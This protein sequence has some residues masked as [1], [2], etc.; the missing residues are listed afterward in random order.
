[1]PKRR[2]SRAP[3]QRKANPLN[4]KLILSAFFTRLFGGSGFN[5][6]QKLL[7]DAKDG[8]NE[9]GHSYVFNILISQKGLAFSADKLEQYD[10]NIKGYVEHINRGREHPVVLKYFQYLAV[11]YSEIF[12]DKYFENPISLLNELNDYAIGLDKNDIFFAKDDLTKLAFWMATGSGKT[13]LMHINYLQFMKYNKGP[14]EI[15]LDNILLITPNEGLS[16]QHIR[17]MEQSGIPCGLFNNSTWG[18]F[19]SM[20]EPNHVQ[21]I[22]IHKFTEEKRGQG[23][24][25][26]VEYFGNRNLIFVDEGHKGSGGEKW[27][28]F[29]KELADEG[30]AFEYSATFGQ[31]VAAATKDSSA[32]VEEYGKAILFDYSYKYFYK[33]GYGKD[34]RILNLKEHVTDTSQDMLMLANLVSFYEQILVFEDN[35]ELIKEYNIEKPLWIFVGSKVKGKREQSDILTIVQFL[36]RALKNEGNWTISSIQRI[37]EGKSGLIDD[38][39]RDIYSPTYPDTKLKYI[40]EKGFTPEEIYRGLLLKVFNVPSSAPLH[41]DNLKK[42]KGEIAL[43]AGSSEFFGVINIGDDAEFLNLVRDKEP[44]IPVKDD[45]L[46]SSLFDSINGPKSKVNILIGA[47]KFT[48]GWNSWRVSNMGLLNIGKKEGSQI[49]QLFGRGVRLKGRDFSLKRSSALE[50]APPKYI[51]ILETLSIFGIKA[52]YMDQFRQY[53]EEEVGPIDNF[54]GIPIPIKVNE[55]YLKEGLLVTYVDKERFKREQF[56]R[57]VVDESISAKVNLTPKVEIIA[58]G[59]ESLEM[60]VS[61]NPPRIIDDKYLQILD[62]EKIYF[63]LLDYR[64]SKGWNN[65]I[66]D[67][68]TLNEIVE[69]QLYELYCPETYIEPQK[70]EDLAKI[71]EIV[72][73]ILKKYIQKY[74]ELNKNNWIQENLDL[75]PI[76]SDHGNLNFGEYLVNAKETSSFAIS[77]AN[78]LATS[79]SEEIPFKGAPG[80]IIDM[81]FDRHLY[82]PLL[83][84]QDIYSSQLNIQPQGLNDG[85]KQFILDL[86]RYLE[87]KSD[88]FRDKMVFL[89]RNLPRRGVGFFETSYFYPDFIIWIKSGETQNIIFVD[90]KGLALNSPGLDEKIM[91]HNRIKGLEKKLSGK[92]N[93]TRVILD[94]FIVSVTSYEDIKGLFGRINR[95]EFED[96]YGVLFQ[97]DNNYIDKLMR[98]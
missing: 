76:D 54:I 85:E 79:S 8:F 32:L 57:L 35:Y 41:L 11:L 47:K 59:P 39:D 63:S 7:K 70:F 61:D 90:P 31:A 84:K 71:S 62:W 5:D 72:E 3:K 95:T 16:N 1:M 73:M 81:D 67:I 36:S 74:F 56:F 15:R 91:L 52:N 55:D 64:I 83:A 25:V 4:D 17:E 9:E 28:D 92:D 94:S 44:G 82:K 12:L 66:F 23:V 2:S 48:E 80:Y 20:V 38:K 10:N 65:L 14:N 96:N 49:I 46:I 22:D 37:L 87:L 50:V 24:T 40:R 58:S 98:I 93:N 13:L 6:I 69:K 51:G 34:Y 97:E 43:R 29:R 77:E 26:D 60:D 42:A 18:Y 68:K 33:D 89:L 19:S 45:E 88:I 21:V 53:L 75:K 78:A 86:K 30:F 27:R